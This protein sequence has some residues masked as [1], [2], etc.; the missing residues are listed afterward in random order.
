MLLPEAFVSARPGARE[1]QGSRARR[2]ACRPG[3]H[4]LPAPTRALRRSGGRLPGR[5]GRRHSRE[6]VGEGVRRPC[7]AALPADFPCFDTCA[8]CPVLLSLI[9][10]PIKGSVFL[11]PPALHPSAPSSLQHCGGVPECAT[12]AVR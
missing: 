7:P 4:A 5:P 2:R 6:D 8:R 10:C 11:E 9:Y 1:A 3:P 12:R